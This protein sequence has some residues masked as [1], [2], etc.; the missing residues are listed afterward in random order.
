MSVPTDPQPPAVP[1]SASLLL[2]WLQQSHDLLALTDASGRIAWVNAAFTRTSGVASNGQLLSLAPPD[3]QGGNAHRVLR[4][5]LQA[6]SLADDTEIGLRRASGEAFWVRA[7]LGRIDDQ[8]LWTL[9]DITAHRELAARAQRQSE[10]LEL[11]QEFGR[12]GIWDRDIP[13][14]KGHWSRQV[15]GF[16]GL[17]PDAGTPDFDEA[18]SRFHP[19]D[20]PSLYLE[21]TR[22]AGRYSQRYRIVRPDGGV[23]WIHSHWVVRNSPAG[24][25]D[26]ATGIMVDDT[27]VYELARSL[28]N[29][30]THLKLAAELGQLVIWRHDLK[31]QR[32]HFNDHGFTVLGIPP[33]ADGLSLDESRTYTHPEDV[34]KLAASAAQALQSGQPVDVQTRHR[35]SDGVWRDMLVRRVV[36]RSPS[37][38]ALA[39]LGVTLDIT[40]QVEQA[41]HAT[42]L[43]RRLE[44]AAEAARVGIWTTTTVG[45]IQ[46]EWNAQMYELF[47]MVGTSAP[48]SLADWVAKCVHPDDAA[49]VA[50]SAQGYLRGDR[51]VFEIEF[52]TR[53]RDGRTR[54]MM[55]RANVD[56][57]DSEGRRVFGIAMDVTDRHEA[58]EAVHA[59][60]QRAALIARHAGIGTWEA[61]GSDQPARWDEQM[62]RLRG[63]EPRA[64]ALDRAERFALV[65]PDDQA[66]VL[67]AHSELNIDAPPAAYEFR[68]RLPDGSYRW[69]ASRSAALRDAHGNVVRRVGVN[70]DIT[71][72]KNA[73][74]ARQQALLAE[75]ESRAKSRF[76]SR[77]SHELRTPLNAVLG[78]TQLLQLEA[79]QTPLPDPST[80][81]GH[82]RAAGEHLLALIDDALDLSGLETGVLKLDLQPVSLAD[83]VAQALPQVERAAAAQG[84]TV[85]AGRLEGQ[86]HADPKRLHQI[87]LNLL[88]NAVKY[89]RQGGQVIVEATATDGVVRLSVRDTGRGLRPEQLAHLFEP[90][91]RLGMDAEGIEGSG[92]GLTIVKAL[93][94][95]MKGHI[96]AASQHGVGTVFEVTLP[97]APANGPPARPSSE[98]KAAPP[99]PRVGRTGQVLYIED[100][101]VNVLLVE[102]LVKSIP[103]L[104]IASEPNGAAGV[105][106]ARSLCPDLILIDMQL[107]DFD[108]FEV[109]RRLRAQPETAGIPCIALSAN[110]MPDDIARGIGGGFDDYWTKPIRFKPFIDALERLFPD[111]SV[112]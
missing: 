111:G 54:W 5:A 30:A 104:R 9:Q 20:K 33:S 25:P 24:H 27:E 86:A 80:R 99:V 4:A 31:T 44:A 102:E 11:A 47:D 2:S 39:F 58:L 23:R 93:V 60:S 101:S 75:R 15:F 55:L 14:G 50:S 17:D 13:S 59:A 109:L 49:R 21:S 26:R 6:G 69:L 61:V 76:L 103:G 41:R 98:E 90:F 57:N 46:T 83:A 36:E 8:W 51:S 3:W 68:V 70:W 56:R 35:R 10:S 18:S 40:D 48:P 110:A 53:L 71:E 52:R 34:P 91:N 38:E 1:P 67:D 88:T 107:P 64:R 65:H 92:I 63:L 95:G 79:R 100:N 73:D 81:L 22:R 43:A 82:I 74:A 85:R 108:G 19:D 105:D 78:F 32:V 12:L 42:R 66:L 84:I 96:G 37:G 87:L 106:R 77:M 28:D 89:N 62:F 29:T 72:S 45:P 94:E 97:A 7:R 112:A 16:W